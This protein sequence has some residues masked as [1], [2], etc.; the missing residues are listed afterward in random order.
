MSENFLDI[1]QI[2][3]LVVTTGDRLVRRNLREIGAARA[4]TNSQQGTFVKLG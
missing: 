2:G 1:H 3:T 4:K